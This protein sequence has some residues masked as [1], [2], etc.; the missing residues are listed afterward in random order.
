M[1]NE[2]P[3]TTEVTETKNSNFARQFTTVTPFSKFVALV[4]FIMLPFVGFWLGT[5]Y[6]NVTIIEYQQQ[7]P[8]ITIEPKEITASTG[9]ES[10][11]TT[12]TSTKE[13][14]TETDTNE[15]VPQLV[16]NKPIVINEPEPEPEIP[17]TPAGYTAATVASHNTEASCW[18]IIR[19]N[20]YD[21]TP[22]L[23]FHSGGKN[24]ILDLCGID[25]TE[26]YLK[27][28]GQET[29]PDEELRNF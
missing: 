16:E 7:T 25:G 5:K 15:A 10:P 6:A 4:T 11:E 23:D 29:K 13:I 26:Q 21:L 20:V 9:T 14:V 8:P 12:P 28:H 2:I 19:D 1:E 22:F 27:E 24:L 17:K 3:Q 18:T